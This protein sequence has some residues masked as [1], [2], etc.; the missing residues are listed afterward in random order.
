MTSQQHFTD[1]TA[2]VHSRVEDTLKPTELQ[3]FQQLKEKCHDAGLLDR[4]NTAD[5]DAHIGIDDDVT[6]LY[7]SI[8]RAWK[9]SF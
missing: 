5:L 6:L 2:Q 8:Q 4:S 9:N 7:A 3:A 1:G